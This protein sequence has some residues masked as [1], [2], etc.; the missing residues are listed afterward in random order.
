MSN[1]ITIMGF[2]LAAKATWV[3]LQ[4][5]YSCM[6]VFTYRQRYMKLKLG[7]QAFLLTVCILLSIFFANFSSLTSRIWFPEWLAN[8]MLPLFLTL[9]KFSHQTHLWE[10][11]MQ[12]GDRKRLCGICAI[13]DPILITFVHNAV[14]RTLEY[15]R[16][17]H[18]MIWITVVY[19]NETWDMM[20]HVWESK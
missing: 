4:K 3:A 5:S 6:C 15:G 8:L 18:F 14:I 7:Q 19:K 17:F 11:S 10:L 2:Y 1:V 12:V 9:L 20:F 16:S 13:K